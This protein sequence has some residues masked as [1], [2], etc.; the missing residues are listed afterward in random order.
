MSKRIAIT[1]I[2][3]FA[4]RHVAER[5]LRDGYQV[6]GI[7]RPTSNVDSLN[8][9]V[10]NRVV[11]H[12]YDVERNDLRVVM[13]EIRP[14]LICHMASCVQ[15]G[16]VYEDVTDMINSNITFG[17]HLL[18]AAISTNCN[19]IINV[20]TYWTHYNNESYNPVNLYAATKE[21][22]KDIILYYEEAWGIQVVTLELFDNYG[23][24]DTRK[25]VFNLLRKS[26]MEEKPL[27]M[28]DCTQM[29][30]FVHVDDLSDAFCFA[31]N[32]MLNDDT[33]KGTYTVAASESLPLRAIVDIFKEYAGDR[34][35]VNI[36]ARPSRAREVMIPWNKG[37]LLPDWEAHIT[38]RDGIKDFL[39]GCI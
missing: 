28:S 38:L 22:F 14:H 30:N 5:L 36:G 1:G 4:G 6:H 33:F 19:K 15:T 12:T 26:I 13:N 9:L 21:A 24:D 3:G 17:T 37:A 25:K 7:V 32:R 10:G 8:T 23:R 16:H 29:V 39:R 11:L 20:S 18:E 35:T 2:S 34:L 27:D 31:T